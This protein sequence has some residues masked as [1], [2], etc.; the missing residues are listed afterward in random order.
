MA[1]EKRRGCGY[2][3]V[4]GLYL[5]CDGLSAPCDRLPFPLHVC[6]TC[7]NGYKQHLGWQWVN[8]FNIF[9]GPHKYVECIDRKLLCVICME[10]EKLKYAGMLWCGG[11]F[12]KHPEDFTREAKEMGVSRRIGAIPHGFKLGETWVLMAH[13]KA[14]YQPETISVDEFI[15]T[16]GAAPIKTGYTPGIFT[17]FKPTAVEKIITDEDAEDSEFMKD[18]TAYSKKVGVPIK[19]VIVPHNDQDH[20]GKVYDDE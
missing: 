15:E 2:R 19:P 18:F 4:G 3:K 10:T 5:V 8:G 9:G 16:E 14:I 17:A 12:Y 6:P 20:Q 11:R 7:G 13:P 1:V